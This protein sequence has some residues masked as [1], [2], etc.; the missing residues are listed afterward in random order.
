ME[1]NDGGVWVGQ[2]QLRLVGHL[3][4]QSRT[5]DGGLRASGA[6]FDVLQAGANVL[7]DDLTAGGLD[8]IDPGL[9]AINGHLD[10]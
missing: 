5:L 10:Q 8:R 3:N 9:V 1:L 2:S 4:A 6:A 7:I